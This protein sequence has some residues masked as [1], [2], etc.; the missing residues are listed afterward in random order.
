[1]SKPLS[2][3][4]GLLFIISGSSGCLKSSDNSSNTES[5][6]ITSLGDV[7]SHVLQCENMVIENGTGSDFDTNFREIGNIVIDENNSSSMFKSYYSVYSEN[8]SQSNQTYIGLAYSMDGIIWEKHPV[9][10]ISRPLEDP[11]VVKH[12]GVFHLFAE[13]KLD[14]PFRNIRK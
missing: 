3:L 1:M 7:Y 14:L 11:Y 5:E 10:V 13:D 4:L 2:I 8:A 9:P 6:I 12:E